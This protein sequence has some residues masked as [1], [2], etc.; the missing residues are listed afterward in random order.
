MKTFCKRKKNVII[1]DL[2]N[3]HNKKDWFHVFH[4]RVFRVFLLIFYFKE[5]N[6]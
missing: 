6:K 5:K 2:Q 4:A 1:K 3:T